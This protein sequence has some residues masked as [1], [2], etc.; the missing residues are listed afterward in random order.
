MPSA[1]GMTIQD[2]R[3]PL[4]PKHVKNKYPAFGLPRGTTTAGGIGI[5]LDDYIFNNSKR[6]EN[7]SAIT[8]S[9]RKTKATESLK[10]ERNSTYLWSRGSSSRVVK[11]SHADVKSSTVKSPPIPHIGI[12]DDNLDL[13]E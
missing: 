8:K 6:T 13:A 11:G 9:P 3:N 12:Q 4:S 2:R 10:D 7:S 1:W 5:G